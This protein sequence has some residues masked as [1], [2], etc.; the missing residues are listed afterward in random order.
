MIVRLW[1]IGG[2][3]KWEIREYQKSWSVPY[4]AYYAPYYALLV[5]EGS[6]LCLYKL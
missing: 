4:Y 3:D 2:V 6:L 5:D 1:N